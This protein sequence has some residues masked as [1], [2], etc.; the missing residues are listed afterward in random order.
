M[1]TEDEFQDLINHR[2]NMSVGKNISMHFYDTSEDK[3]SSWEMSMTVIYSTIAIWGICSNVWV[4]RAV[5]TLLL[6]KTHRIANVLVYITALACLNISIMLSMS[7][8][9]VQFII[10]YWPFG[11]YICRLHWII[12][13]LNK[14]MA[15]VI[16]SLLTVACYCAVCHP[17]MK[18]IYKSKLYAVISVTLGFIL[19]LVVMSRPAVIHTNVYNFIEISRNNSLISVFDRKCLFRPSDK[20]DVLYFTVCSFCCGYVIPIITMTLSYGSILYTVRFRSLCR[21]QRIGH[22]RRVARSVFILV[23]FYL[24]SWTPYWTVTLAQYVKHDKPVLISITF[25]VHLLPYI[26]CAFST[27]LYSLLNSQ[28]R[29]VRRNNKRSR[30]IIV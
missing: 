18:K 16:L 26:N 13:T 3:M 9:V 4:F 20:D 23:S 11:N 12:E 30:R 24:T 28:I 8:T 29:L 19:V 14:T 1:I 17:K 21:K 6:R 27:L 7:T 25:I 22:F 15:S 10:G 2:D 5:S